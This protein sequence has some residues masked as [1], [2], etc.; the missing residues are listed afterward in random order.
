MD[1]VVK[2]TVM[3]A[4]MRNWAAFNEVYMTYFN[5]NRLPARSAFGVSGL[6]QGA[7]L[8]VECIAYTPARKQN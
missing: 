1:N 7:P 4:D 8:E 6:A 5:S 3:L 2:C